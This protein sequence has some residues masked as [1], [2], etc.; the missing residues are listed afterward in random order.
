MQRWFRRWKKAKVSEFVPDIFVLTQGV[1]DLGIHIGA[2]SSTL[3]STSSLTRKNLSRI[4][5]HQFLWYF[6]WVSSRS[7]I[8]NWRSELSQ[9]AL[10]LWV[11]TT[12]SKTA[13]PMAPWGCLVSVSSPW[14]ISNWSWGREKIDQSQLLSKE[15]ML[16]E[17]IDP[18]LR[19][20]NDSEG[21][22][23]KYLS[24]VTVT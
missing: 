24:M 17:V 21:T 10:L 23:C 11:I 19:Q 14:V 13:P 9:G 6:R 18:N 1:T 12:F 15:Q 4:L 5:R 3:D 20:L 22:G 16:L 8:N 2:W 7:F